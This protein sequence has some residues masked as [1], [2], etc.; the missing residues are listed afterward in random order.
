LET[1]SASAGVSLD[2]AVS[3]KALWDRVLE[4]ITSQRILK[5]SKGKTNRNNGR[6]YLTRLAT[7]FGVQKQLAGREFVG[8]LKGCPRLEGPIQAKNGVWYVKLKKKNTEEIGTDDDDDDDGG[9]GDGD[10]DASNM[11]KFI[12]EAT[13]ESIKDVKEEKSHKAVSNIMVEPIIEIVECRDWM[14][15]VSKPSG[16]STEELVILA[17]KQGIAKDSR[18]RIQDQ[19]HVEEDYK[20]QTVSRLDQPTSGLEI[21]KSRNLEILKISKKSD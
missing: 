15:V 20:I 1:I 17:M 14:L 16:M 18:V 13:P 5:P 8:F 11:S 12:N 6:Y 9:V 2:D 10:G 21:L 4:L 19:E 7:D 3:Q